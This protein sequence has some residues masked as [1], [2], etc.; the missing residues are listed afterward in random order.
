[1]P[2][3]EGHIR[4]CAIKKQPKEDRLKY[5]ESRRRGNAVSIKEFDSFWRYQVVCIVGNR[6]MHAMTLNSKGIL[7]KIGDGKNMPGRILN[8]FDD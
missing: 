2:F 4:H 6:T 3:S 8:L 7:H 5:L 1:M